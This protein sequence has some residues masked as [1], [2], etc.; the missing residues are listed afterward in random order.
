[1]ASDTL[2]PSDANKDYCI[3]HVEPTAKT[4]LKPFRYDSWCR[5][6][7]CAQRWRLL[8]CQEGNVA[9]ETETKL[10]LVLDSYDTENYH[11][12]EHLHLPIPAYAKFHAKCY[13]RFCN[14]TMLAREEKREEKRKEAKRKSEAQGKLN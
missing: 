10:G 3:F 14:I 12:D 7:K 1:M 6:L 8:D 11:A 4:P 2:Q 13:S 9:R 5:F